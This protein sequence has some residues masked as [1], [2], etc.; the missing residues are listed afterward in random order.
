MFWMNM[1]PQS[2]GVNSWAYKVPKTRQLS[3]E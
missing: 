2:Y 1:L 3:L